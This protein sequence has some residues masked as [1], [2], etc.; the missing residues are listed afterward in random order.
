MYQ[1]L[2]QRQMLRFGSAMLVVGASLVEC[3]LAQAADSGPS[4]TQ[5]ASTI[6][7]VSHRSM[8]GENLQ[9]T[10]LASRPT[11]SSV[12]R[13][14][15][16]PT[17]TNATTPGA[18]SVV[19]DARTSLQV[20]APQAQAHINYALNL[21]ERGA[22]QSAQAE[23]TMALTLIADALDADAKN[24]PR[25]HARAAQAGL[26][27]IKETKDFV[28]ADAPH[29]IE[30]NV[31]QLAATHQTPILRGV[32]TTA[33][34][35]AD[36]LQRYHTYATQQL[37]FA[38]GQSTIA[39]QA[40]YGLGRAECVTT[41]GAGTRNRLGSP[42]AMAF[43]QAA[44]LVDPQ[45]YMASNELG[46]LMARFGDLESAA[47]Q[48][49]HSL[50]IKPQAE[51][52]HNLATVFRRM[53]E[54]ELADQAD[55]ERATLLAATRNGSIRGGNST[56]LASRPTMQ[57]VD[58]DTFAASASPYS[59]DGPAVSSSKPAPVA[60]QESFGKRLMA[61]VIPRW[62][63]DKSHSS[64]DLTKLSSKTA[65]SPVGATEGRSLFK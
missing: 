62:N 14:Q 65:P 7:V 32:D 1:E 18:Q 37:A 27:A 28:P 48:L 25:A 24:S 43:F 42:N 21:A 26:T 17:A 8:S 19:D 10:R 33:L 22:V 2:H 54:S 9:V 38:G 53:G 40:L 23:F 46:V 30:I 6:V 57:W 59:F 51:T 52:W 58:N 15:S 4:D 5:P 55:Q 12:A 13:A 63:A 3:L 31:A 35:R 50:T 36:A 16:A 34:T 29:D 49:S 47:G 41:A 61:K 39:S 45:N 56:D 20:I 60:K 64:T 11:A 44:L